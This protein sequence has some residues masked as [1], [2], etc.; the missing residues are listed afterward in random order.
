MENLDGC[1]V[2]QLSIYPRLRSVKF[3][4]L[5]CRMVYTTGFCNCFLP[6][7]LFSR[8]C[9]LPPSLPR[10]ETKLTV[11]DGSFGRLSNEGFIFLHRY[12]ALLLSLYVYIYI[13]KN[14]GVLISRGTCSWVESE[15]VN[16]IYVPLLLS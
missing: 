7:V 15:T 1:S 14:E 2:G 10:F 6:D 4:C 11:D 13:K 9:F 5:F 16:K 8:D 3:V 12:S